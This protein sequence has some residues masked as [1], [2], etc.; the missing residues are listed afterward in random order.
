MS[1]RK[2]LNRGSNQ[3]SWAA[4]KQAQDTKRQSKL[5]KPRPVKEDCGCGK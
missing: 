1:F 2:L 3:S 5:R 4:K